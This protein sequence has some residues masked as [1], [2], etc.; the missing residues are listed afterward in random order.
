M[1][2]VYSERSVEGVILAYWKV[3]RLLGDRI[4]EVFTAF[5][6]ALSDWS[7]CWNQASLGMNL[8]EI[9]VSV[10]LED[11]ISSSVK[12]GKGVWEKEL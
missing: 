2:G 6:P 4:R 12:E 7:S 10:R 11:F 3:V 9:E 1:E 8:M 5:S